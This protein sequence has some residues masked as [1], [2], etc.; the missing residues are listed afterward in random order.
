MFGTIREFKSLK[1]LARSDG[2]SLAPDS[3]VRRFTN[4]RWINPT[5]QRRQ[6][7][8]RVTGMGTLVE[9]WQPLEVGVSHAPLCTTLS[10]QCAA[11][12]ISC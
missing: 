7:V 2:R 10:L 1:R 6:R 9:K 12:T 8:Q 3:V 4:G 11:D 5:L